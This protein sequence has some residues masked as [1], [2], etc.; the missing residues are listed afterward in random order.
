LRDANVKTEKSF[1]G[2]T[3][4]S[5]GALGNAIQGGVIF[6]S[7][8][9]YISA[10][11]DHFGAERSKITLIETFL[12]VGVNI[13]SPAIGLLVDRW[14]VRYSM[15]IGALA[16][17][18]GLI[19]CSMAGTLLSVWL[20]FI[21][22]IP[23]GVLAI[24]A[25]PS[26]TVISRWFRKRRGLALGISVAGSSVG[27]AL[28][29][30]ILT[31]L[32]ISYGWRTGML[33][34]GVFVILLSPLFFIFVADHPQDKGMEQER[35]SSNKKLALS[36]VDKVD[37]RV[38]D[39]VQTSAFWKQTI[40]SGSLL[41]VTLG[42]L[43]NLGL[44]A[45]DLG[46]VGQ[47][48]ALLYSIIAFCS[49]LGKIGFGHLIDRLGLTGAGLI[50]VSLMSLG[51]FALSLVDQWRYLAMTCVV[52]GFAIGGTSPM[53]TNM[54]ARGFGARSFGRTMGIMNPAHIPL[55]APSAPM[56]AYVSDATGSYDLVFMVYIGVMVV[57]GITLC[58]L[59]P[60][61]PKN[62]NA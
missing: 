57:A 36:E 49:F 46:F 19:V 1:Y 6:W 30:P 20:A 13:L 23:L 62:T 32:F 27:G 38:R 44:H 35:D 41:G 42:L 15:T 34:I 14:S 22:F 25:L 4:T 37:W 11:E 5:M 7:M 26:S 51:L 31:W 33:S 54:I 17:G 60:P 18:L 40:I 3:I 47:E 43:A 10:F 28:L 29:P 45:K 61:V 48:V 39:I 16:I 53:W 58:I 56:A 12:T 59:K 2:W 24:G 9:I 52:V 8:G 21:L 55:T 50:A